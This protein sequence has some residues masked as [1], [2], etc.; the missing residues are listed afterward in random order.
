MKFSE[1]MDAIKEQEVMSLLLSNG[2]RVKCVH[3]TLLFEDEVG[4][5]VRILDSRGELARD[6]DRIEKVICVNDGCYPPGS[7]LELWDGDVLEINGEPI[8]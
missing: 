8:E 2:V 7:L 5:C 3:E 1:A 4:Y 6:L